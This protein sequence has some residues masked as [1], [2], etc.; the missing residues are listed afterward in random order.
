[1]SPFNVIIN[2]RIINALK[3]NGSQK[4][5][6]R[7]TQWNKLHVFWNKARNLMFRKFTFLYFQKSFWSISFIPCSFLLLYLI[8][9]I[10]NSRSFKIP[11]NPFPFDL[12]F[13]LCF[14]NFKKFHLCFWY[15]IF[16]FLSFLVLFSWLLTTFI[17][18]PLP[19]FSHLQAFSFLFFL[20][21]LSLNSIFFH[22]YQIWSHYLIIYLSVLSFFSC[23]SLIFTPLNQ[24]SCYHR[25]SCVVFETWLVFISHS[26][27]FLY[28]F[29]S[30]LISVLFLSPYT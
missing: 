6:E 22:L 15:S 11:L 4:K 3:T 28:S 23:S 17:C 8:L 26:R 5:I 19:F 25:R 27:F 13:I 30:F 1:M 14:Y 24:P 9:I 16:E 18:Y 10:T 20:S 21:N 7:L 12:K 2:F 29:Y